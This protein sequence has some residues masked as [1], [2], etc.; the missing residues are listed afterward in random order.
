MLVLY[1]VL[2]VLVPAAVIL[3]PFLRRRSGAGEVVEDESSAHAELARRWDAALSSLKSAELERAVGNLTEEDY[4]WLRRQY[5]A[6]AVQ[7]MKAMELE[8]QQEQE[9]L[10]TIELEVE[11][12]RVRALGAANGQTSERREERTGA[13]GE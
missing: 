8:E 5:L 10:A 7:V 12:A 9:L 2:I 3:Y 11:R 4:Q 6:E 1:A 13:A